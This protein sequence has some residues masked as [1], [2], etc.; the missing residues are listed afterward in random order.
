MRDYLVKGLAFDGQ[1]RVYAAHT[2]GIV[3]K[4][5]QNHD[6]WPVATAALGRTM[7]ATAMM[8]S[9]LK[10]EES[11][12][13]EIFGM[14]F[15]GKV[16]AHANNKGEV[17]GYVSNPHV[18]VDS[19]TPNKLNVGG[20]VGTNGA[21][22]IR[23]DLGLKEPWS[24]SVQ[25]Q[26]GEIGDDFTYYFAVSEQTPSAVGLGVL[27]DPT[28]NGVISSGGFIL[29]MMPDV[30]EETISKL[31]ERLG[32]LPPVS[33]LVGEGKSPEEIIETL[34]GEGNY[35]VLDSLD[36]S[37]TCDCSKERF[38]NGLKS[39]GEDTLNN[40]LE[41]VEPIETTCHFCGEKYYF[42]HDEI[43]SLK[44]AE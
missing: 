21:L 33:H 34:V 22:T 16:I 25:L 11:L 40:L 2:T 17:I 19:D 41:D 13:S 39:L 23:K 8:G 12:S 14:G 29:Q 38:S 1:V 35:Q 18:H 3:D 5:Q 32:S 28:N 26:T 10:G 27:V 44:N 7:T 24:G 36:L 42:S 31:E 9:M 37:Y 15:I 6:T 43:K 20:A 30:T 4:A